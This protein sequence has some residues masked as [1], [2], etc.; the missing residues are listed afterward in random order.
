MH[1][2]H[3]CLLFC[4]NLHKNGEKYYYNIGAPISVMPVK[5]TK[6]R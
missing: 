3:F 4:K 2:Y 6:R 1:F 5:K